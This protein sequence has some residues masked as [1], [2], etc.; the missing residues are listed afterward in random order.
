[1]QQHLKDWTITAQDADNN[2]INLHLDSLIAIKLISESGI[3]K[4]QLDYHNRNID[5]IDLQ[6]TVS[7]LDIQHASNDNLNIGKQFV[8][9]SE[10]ALST[11][12]KSYVFIIHQND[13]YIPV[14]S[15]HD[16]QSIEYVQN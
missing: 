8:S 10:V 16:M 13:K 1:M 4:I 11:Y 7:T 2:D 15:V 14:I 12:T 6:N 5:A 9:T 3:N